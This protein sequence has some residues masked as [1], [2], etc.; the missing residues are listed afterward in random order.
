M[1][2]E[3]EAKVLGIDPAVIAD[4]I[5]ACGGVGKGGHLLRRYV[6]DIAAGDQSRWLRLRAAGG[7]VTLTVKQVVHDGIDRVEETEVTVGD[8]DAAGVLLDKLGFAAKSYQ[9]NHR[10]SFALDGA[11]LEIDT[12]PQIPAYLEIEGDSREHVLAVA[13][14]LGYDEAELTAANTT[15]V[16]AGYGIDLTAI[17]ELRF[18]G[19]ESIGSLRYRRPGSE[20]RLL[21]G[22][23]V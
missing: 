4:R 12:W 22:K 3:F 16:Y 23:G 1:S 8:F 2:I 6:Y 15:A 10:T 21:S 5:V 18:T 19:T 14:R 11:R 17:K 9:E 20:A 7:E 13:R